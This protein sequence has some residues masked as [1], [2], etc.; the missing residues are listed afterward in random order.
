[1]N[2]FSNALFAG[3]V[4]CL[5][6]SV[7]RAHAEIPSHDPQPLDPFGMEAYNKTHYSHDVD[8]TLHWSGKDPDTGKKFKK[9]IF[10]GRGTK[11]QLRYPAKGKEKRQRDREILEAALT[12][13]GFKQI[14]RDE[15]TLIAV[16]EGQ[17]TTVHAEILYGWNYEFRLYFYRTRNIQA[18]TP[19]EIVFTGKEIPKRI[20][21]TQFDG[22]QLYRVE[23]EILE[24]IGVD[25]DWRL[26]YRPKTGD[27]TSIR[28][29]K[30]ANSGVICDG[31]YYKKFHYFD[32]PPY[33]GDV[34]FWVTPL[35]VRKKD[36]KP[37]PNTRVKLSLIKT[38][39]A[40]PS[41]SN[42]PETGKL[43]AKPAL[44]SFKNA[45]STLPRVEAQG[46]IRGDFQPEGDYLPNGDAAY[47]LNN[48]F[49]TLTRGGLSSQ[50]VPLRADHETQV[51]WPLLEENRKFKEH[52]WLRPRTRI[53]ILDVQKKDEE[54]LTL[55][56]AI[57]ELP[58]KRP[59]ELDEFS[60]VEAGRV[61]GEILGL[62]N[63]PEPMN[64]VILLDS[65]GSMKHSMKTAINS[66]DRFIKKLPQNARVT[67][68]DF[69]TTVKPIPAKDR[70][71]QLEKLAR[72]K[73]NG[74]TALYDSVLA[75]I[76]LLKGKT[77]PA[78]VLFTDGKDANYNDTKR[79][80]VA[81]FDA[82][83][84]SVQ[85][86]EIPIY[87]VG[88]GDGADT[89]TLGALAK[90]T[91]TQYYAG[92]DEKG[93]D[94]IFT[95]I[96]A[97]LSNVFRMEIKRGKV[98][99]KESPVTVSYMVDTSGSMDKR[100][101]MSPNAPGVGNRFEPLKG[102]LLESIQSLPQDY[103]VQLSS[104][105]SH[106]HTHQI[107]TQDKAKLLR[108]IGD[109]EPGGGTNIPEALEAGLELCTTADTGR[110]Y[111]IFI[112]DAAGNAFNFKE[113]KAKLVKTALINFKNAGIRT[114][115]LGMYDDP[116]SVARVREFANISG[117]EA[118]VSRD[119]KL[120]KE[121]ILEFTRKIAETAPTIKARGNVAL[122]FKRRDGEN[123]SF[124][125][126][127][128]RQAVDFDPL[129]D[130]DVVKP[131]STFSHRIK[132]KDMDAL[133]YNYQAADKIYGNDTPLKEVRVKKI[134]PLVDDNGRP[135]S[136]KNK[137]VEIAVSQA[138]LFSRL[139]GISPT[140][141]QYLTLDLTLKNIL[142]SQE[143][144]VLEDGQGHPSAFIGKSN[145]HTTTKKAIP[146]Y[147]IPN[148]KSHL[149]VRVNNSHEV[150]FSPITWALGKPL[151]PMDAHEL[152]VPGKGEPHERKRSG[153]LAFRIPDK[154]VSQ[155]SL[156]F[157]D[158]NYGHVDI[159]IIGEMSPR[160]K[161]LA[162]LP[163]TAP[164]QLGEAFEIEV[165]E[166]KIGEQLAGISA[167][168]GR[169]FETLSCTLDSRV[170]ALLNLDPAKRF[171]LKIP[172]PRGDR[173]IPTHPVTQKI[174]LGFFKDV[175]VAPGSGNHFALA[176]HLPREL[177]HLP[178]SLFVELKGEDV[179]IPLPPVTS[180]VENTNQDQTGKS[181]NPQKA[182]PVAKPEVPDTAPLHVA[183]ADGIDLEINGIYKLSRLD[184]KRK[185]GFV[186]D[187]TLK[188]T[189]DQNATRIRKP[190]L[191]AN[192]AHVNLQGKS[193]A[194]GENRAAKKGLGGFANAKAETDGSR[195][196][197]SP[198]T[199]TTDRILGYP[200][201]TFDG[202]KRRSLVL[203]GADKLKKNEKLYLVSLVFPDLKYEFDPATLAEFKENWQLLSRVNLPKESDQSE[204]DRLL[205]KIRS[206]RVKENKLAARP[207]KKRVGLDSPKEL[208]QTV[209]PISLGISGA[210]RIKDI[211]TPSQAVEALKTL[212]W[213]PSTS[214]YV[215]QSPQ[216]M[217]TQGWG[218]DIDMAAYLGRMADRRNARVI[219]GTYALT[220]QGRSEMEKMAGPIK[221]KRKRVPFVEWEEDG[222]THS[223]VF[224]FFKEAD[225][226]LGL[227]EP[228]DRKEKDKY[229]FRP[230]TYTVA[231]RLWYKI[232]K[233]TAA[234]QMGSM[235]G[236]LSGGSEKT[237]KSQRIF[238]QSFSIPNTDTAMAD[239]WFAKGKD[240]K[241]KSLVSVFYTHPDGQEMDTTK[242]DQGAI[243]VKLLMEISD[244]NNQSKRIIRFKEG[245]RLSD[246]FLTISLGAPD[247]PEPA[248]KSLEAQAKKQ[249]GNIKNL[250][251]FCLAAWAN[252]Q[253]IISFLG[254]QTRME[255][256]LA[257]Q[258]GVTAIHLTH[259]RCMV[260]GLE[261]TRDGR[262]ISSL[263]LRHTAPDLFGDKEK[264]RAFALASGLLDTGLEGASA[265]E[266][267]RT[268]FSLWD[269]APRLRILPL[270]YKH[271]KKDMA[272]MEKAGIPATIL[273]RRKNSRKDWLFP[274]KPIQG[275]WGWLEIDPKTFTL[276]SVLDDGSNGA[277]TETI[278]TQENI[279]TTTR[280]FLGLLIGTNISVGSVI[281]Y[282][283]MAEDYATIKA[284]AQKEAKRLACFVKKM[285]GAP[286]Q[287]QDGI[288]SAK[289][290][291]A[292]AKQVASDMKKD[293]KGTLKKEGKAAVGAVKDSLAKGKVP[294]MPGG[295]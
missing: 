246:L 94:A 108:A 89:V 149:F 148:L 243:P 178:Q 171:F 219:R 23:L 170:N 78:I 294:E 37:Q 229:G 284:K 213:V 228:D 266:G 193:M 8:L 201:I 151:T 199:A 209:D 183:R 19:K 57:T 36:G 248:I 52:A 121:K 169:V 107:F 68:V 288:K 175:S 1:M 232:E 77:R 27:E 163:Q 55:D 129:E 79:G 147:K 134:L 75:G 208:P 12:H 21:N 173:L 74:A 41:I 6:F 10:A 253:K 49:Y 32:L 203:F 118:F 58:D 48:G 261:R 224:P 63:L 190:I 179:E 210:D 4:F 287:V 245:Q 157:Y 70:A 66:V 263:D 47:W 128:A 260:A 256:E 172:T 176:F 161:D 29:D 135:I 272:K 136:G 223:L 181:V 26:D 93:L 254:G 167:G 217:F 22:K 100:T 137:A 18:D 144:V 262:F 204:L 53:N 105:A 218:R 280:Y 44:L 103:Y 293:A 186:V 61:K 276:T 214:Q 81:D 226:L 154:P 35:K 242:L 281:N 231:F 133:S 117:G 87:P 211:V 196:F 268:V 116:V 99:V 50:L 155:L 220:G 283:L 247:L 38:P 84:R 65:S 185:N 249:L 122:G 162:Q 222:E 235:G 111:F 168:K 258:L 267:S 138:Q 82:M 177:G 42:A 165:K 230:E 130:P 71:E 24:G 291:A 2:K 101:T 83:M 7:G 164:T 72:I 236:A 95:S 198:D 156:H 123:G 86:H 125:A 278:L 274:S 160:K 98:P 238:K 85:N 30:N 31:R 189:Q 119:A 200:P 109:L 153:I 239:F 113:D 292:K 92:S 216:A 191:L 174:P 289:S 143:V 132:K 152:V 286:G 257:A 145:A 76:K 250:E 96:A 273:E 182:V 16:Q 252:R 110:A 34:V 51:T 225:D 54:N 62:E 131:F 67:L 180:P 69:D 11:W 282:A 90:A 234:M 56:F 207:S 146:A 59:L 212:K 45:F 39:H 150:S 187:I 33:Q 9:K 140:R 166:R 259:H 195:I 221:V 227:I 295:M 241:G 104:F 15:E 188:D 192:A 91:A 279:E 197:V 194:A 97:S 46:Y 202:T 60:F 114:F 73:P 277:M 88:F 102:S 3:L 28:Y 215:V 112:T 14:Y 206:Q 269:Q 158:K 13:G 64:L 265:G 237:L 20:F 240:T 40:L 141:S 205:K 25:L 139:K 255:K 275:S 115:W 159:P 233:S 244:G 285:E 271:R 126:T 184:G 290:G 124:Y 120:V 17:D 251:P 142:E 43:S 264:R 5:L 106:V 80:S 270:L 127:K